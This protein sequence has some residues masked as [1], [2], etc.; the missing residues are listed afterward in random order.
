[1]AEQ[2]DI[3]SGKDACRGCGTE[4]GEGDLLYSALAEGDDGFERRDFCP[5]C[6]EGLSGDG[7]FCFWRTRKP[8]TDRGRRL[9]T[10]LMLEF[11]DRLEGA[12][13]PEKAT[14]RFVIGLYLIRRKELKLLE[15]ERKEEGEFLV[16]ERRGTGERVKLRNPGLNEEQIQQ[17]AAR[18]SHLFH[19]EL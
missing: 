14:F 8:V 12:A 2:W 3:V 7:F 11:F 1:M 15:T 10:E 19:A 13:E 4:F 9:D 18:L 16:C 6:W 17:T 5:G